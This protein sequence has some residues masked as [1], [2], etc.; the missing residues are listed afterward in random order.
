MRVLHL[1]L[2]VGRDIVVLQLSP[3]DSLW[4]TGLLQGVFFTEPPPKK[5]E[6]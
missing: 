4:S 5:L 1:Y 3:P 6:Y 2:P